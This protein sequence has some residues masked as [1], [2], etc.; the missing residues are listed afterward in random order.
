M[1]NGA[2]W[3]AG[4]AKWSAGVPN[5]SAGVPKIEPKGR[6]K[7]P[8]WSAGGAKW[9]AGVP[10]GSAGVPGSEKDAEDGLHPR[11]LGPIF[12]SKKTSK[13]NHPKT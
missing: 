13:I 3:S 2:K 9:S 11:L 10:N 8:K 1:P 5:W 7:Q 4:V 6:Q 12:P